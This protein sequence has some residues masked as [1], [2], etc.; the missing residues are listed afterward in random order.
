MV[1][2]LKIVGLLLVVT[3]AASAVALAVQAPAKQKGK[4][5][6][7]AEKPEVVATVSGTLVAHGRSY[8]LAGRGL[9]L[10]PPWWRASAKQADYDGDGTV[11][12]IAAELQGLVGKTVS[13]TGA[14]DDGEQDELS[15]RTLNGSAYRAH[16]RPPWAGGRNR[17]AKCKAKAAKAAA[18]AKKKDTGH[19]PPPWAPAHGKRCG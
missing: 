11:E 17:E 19:G 7:K 5:P 9:G 3:L 14:T 6:E 18:K 16:G 15:V 13:L 1:R 2:V 10:G 4:Q 8:T 12:T